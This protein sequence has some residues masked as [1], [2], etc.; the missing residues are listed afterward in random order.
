M[1]E[2]S[3][4][5]IIWYLSGSLSQREDGLGGRGEENEFLSRGAVAAY[6]KKRMNHTFYFNSTLQIG[7]V[8][9]C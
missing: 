1:S 4:Y 6:N 5:G 9:G 8:H 2:P 3:G 7:Q